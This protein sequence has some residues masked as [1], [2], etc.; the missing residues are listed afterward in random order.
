MVLKRST[1]SSAII[2]DS[3][4]I[5]SKPGLSILQDIVTKGSL[6]IKHKA[7]QDMLMLTKWN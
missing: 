6:H 5:Q 7:V 1:D 4:K 3:E 2:D